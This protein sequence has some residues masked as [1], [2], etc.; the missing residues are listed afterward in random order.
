MPR[1]R[2]EGEALQEPIDTMY[3][4]CCDL[5]NWQVWDGRR[6][7]RRGLH[8]PSLGAQVYANRFSYT[9]RKLPTKGLGSRRPLGRSTK[10]LRRGAVGIQVMELLTAQQVVCVLADSRVA[11]VQ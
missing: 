9:Y 7:G 10:G 8:G 11:G 2:K 4:S 1:G 5:L 6:W 3:V